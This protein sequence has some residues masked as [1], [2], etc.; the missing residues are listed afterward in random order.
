MEYDAYSDDL[1]AMIAIEHGE[2]HDTLVI[3][4]SDGG[5]VRLPI[6]DPSRYRGLCYNVPYT[7]SVIN[8]W[9]RELN[10]IGE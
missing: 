7:M 3:F 9:S 4:T 6:S 1:D 8:E 2:L 10:N 5:E